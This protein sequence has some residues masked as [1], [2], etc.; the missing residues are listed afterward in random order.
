MTMMYTSPIDQQ[1]LTHEGEWLVAADGSH[2]FAVRCGIPQLIK[3]DRVAVAD[4]FASAYGL[5]RKVEGRSSE[6][7]S[8]YRALPYEDLSNK[9]PEQWKRRSRSFDALVATI[10]EAPLDVVDA[11][12]GNCWLAARL[13]GRGHSVVAVDLNDD[14]HDGLGAH[15]NYTETFEVARA[16]LTAM[17]LPSA[18]VDLVVFNASVHYIDLDLGVDEAIRVLRGGG[19]VIIADSPVYRDPSAGESMTLDLREHLRGLGVD[20]ADHDG[21]GFLTR[22][23]LESSSLE[24]THVD[25]DGGRLGAVRRTIAGR[26]AG[27]ELAT[28]PLLVATVEESNRMEAA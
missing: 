20:P 25:L 28:L 5:V 8:Y 1:L 16:E 6:T 15:V 11:G 17:P 4:Q 23:Q 12:S 18:S 10:G 26:R 21:P 7:P 14:G 27:R 19:R 13:A 2:R 22:H 24:W 3:P 9:F